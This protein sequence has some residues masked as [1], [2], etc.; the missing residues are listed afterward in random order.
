MH[1]KLTYLFCIFSLATLFSCQTDKIEADSIYFNGQF[2]TLDTISPSASAI[3]I[4]DGR[5]LAIGSDTDILLLEGD[6]TKTVDL[7]SA[8]AM[9]GFIEGHGHFS[10]LG[11]GLMNLNFMYSKNWEEITK[12]VSTKAANTPKGEWVV[13]RGWHQEKWDSAP[14]ISIDNYP[15]H[16]QLSALTKDHPIL[17]SH[18]SGHALFANEKAMSIAGIT[19][20][21][22]DPRGGHIVRDAHGQAIGVFEEEA[23]DLIYD[24]YVHYRNSLDPTTL[25]KEW[26]HGIEL[27]ENECLAKGITSFQDAGASFKQIKDYQTLAEQGDLDLRLWTMARASYNE[28]LMGLKENFPII[29]AGESF[30]TCRAIKSELDGALGSF[31]AWLLEPYTDKPDFI[32]QNTT[33][34]ATIDSM[35]TL[36]MKKNMQ[37]CVHSIGDKANRETLNVFEEHFKDQEG[38]DLRW[39]I[40]HSQHIDTT[41]IPRFAALGVI[42]SMQAIHCTSD[43]PFVEKR[44][45]PDR[46]RTGAYPWRSLLDAGAVVTNGTDTPVEDVDPIA[47]F[48]A[49][50][51]RKSAHGGAAFYPEQAMTREEAIHAYTMANAFAAFEEKDKGSI[52]IGKLADIVVLS[53]DLLNCTDDEILKTNVLMTIVGGKI[54]YKR[55]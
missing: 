22:P 27:A 31:G 42:A 51:T 49:S 8:F 53:N 32:G 23:M 7:H 43:A 20:E 39:R 16:Q 54:K 28:T 6:S 26:L 21:T 52:S 14:K 18:A 41:D 30:F 4:K 17:L 38:K 13:G 46:A 15:T 3:A 48:Y 33:L 24:A 35:A 2:H 9:P 36:A 11:M 37:L 12:M 5:I 19:S 1:S 29:N 50:V 47:S 55:D 25:H 34:V 40:E 10:S 45:G 44:L